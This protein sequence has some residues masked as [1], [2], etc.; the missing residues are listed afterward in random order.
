MEEGSRIELTPEDAA[1]SDR[2]QGRLVRWM[3]AREQGGAPISIGEAC[4][5]AM[6]ATQDYLHFSGHAA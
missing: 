2:W 3:R 1:I 5:V 6:R 4:G